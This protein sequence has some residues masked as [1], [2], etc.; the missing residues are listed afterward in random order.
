VL[1]GSM[2]FLNG[3]GVSLVSIAHAQRP[4]PPAA[5]P[6]PAKPPADAKPNLNEAKKRYGAG[7]KKYND[8]DYAGA[9]VEFQAADAIKST[10]HATRYIGLCQEQL[11][12]FQEAVDAYEKFLANV[13]KGMDA[14]ADDIKARVAKIKAMPGK[15]HFETVP[16]GAQIVVDD[17][18]L[19]VTPADLDVAPGTHTIKLVL[20]KYETK[21]STLDVKYASKAS[22]TET[23]MAKAV[24]TT[25]PP[26]ATTT[27]PPPASTAP[28]PPP[29]PAEARSMLPAY[30]TGGLAIAA[31][32]VGAIFGVIALGDKSDF[33]KNPT[34]SKADD[35]EN[36]ALIADM[37]FFVAV[38]LG[39]TSAVLF[40][41]RDDAPA[42]TGSA[43]AHKIGSAT[44]PKKKSFTITPTP[45]VTP[46]G[47]GM[48]AVIRF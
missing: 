13:P 37:A 10:G 25:P 20:D 9:L 46:T 22:V 44:P 47:G 15:V 39:V 18:P 1:A 14:A 2:A 21:T 12:H 17:K 26:V 48:G 24:D 23:L 42:A 8:K 43:G 27:A 29:P 35:G 16:A 41:T 19:G 33:D 30:I 3:G 40:L 28:P 38:T 34:S 4:K 6:P 45:I 11:G 32:G 7:E 36:H 31:A 5:A